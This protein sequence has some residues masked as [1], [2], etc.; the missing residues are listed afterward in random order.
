MKML[1]KVRTARLRADRIARAKR[2]GV[3]AVDKGDKQTMSDGT[4]YY[5]KPPVFEMV[6][7]GP[8][9][10]VGILMK[11]APGIPFKRVWS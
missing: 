5:G 7:Q 2:K 4:V 3:T 10:L 8:T 9:D 1:K 6:K 11:T